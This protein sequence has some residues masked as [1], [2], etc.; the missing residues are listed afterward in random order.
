MTKLVVSG[1]GV[2]S[3]IGVG[4]DAFGAS[5]LAGATR[6]SVMQ[7]HGRQSEESAFLGAEIASLAPVTNQAGAPYRALS[8]STHA[9][10]ATV[11]EAYADA[12]LATAVPE[13][14][15]L[16]LGGSNL[17][18]RESMLALDRVRSRPMYTPPNHAVSYMDTDVAAWCA[19]HFGLRGAVW[20]A[21]GASASGLL[22]LVEAAR[23]VRSGELD[24]CIAVGGLMDLSHLECHAFR[25]LGAMGSDKFAT[26]PQEAC[27]PFDRGHDG[28][29]FGE[30]CA[31][32]VVESEQSARR[33]GRRPYAEIAGWSAV[34]DANRTPAPSL[35]G[36]VRA[37]GQALAHAGWN[38]GQI[39]YVNPHGSGSVVGD[40]VEL[41][42]LRESGLQGAWLNATK[43][44][45]GHGLSAAGALEA[46]A[47]MVQ[48]RAGRLHPTANLEQPI[49]AARWVEPGGA[50]VRIDKALKLSLGFGGINIAM[51]FRNLSE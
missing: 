42:A 43:S 44:L 46:A 6:F 35:E 38:A 26:R 23:A 14:I 40:E 21:G 4:V 7:R 32:L 34:S 1:L 20:T 28:F 11:G 45:T 22:A 17:Q 51:C 31:A 8:L 13:R 18:Q 48:M 9:A 30:G 49:G 37:I 27:R 15:G 47:L 33:R 19:Q 10:L 12:C 24:I 25:S 2:S 16:V 36:E 41:A 29:I 39:D 5:L 50:A 3:A